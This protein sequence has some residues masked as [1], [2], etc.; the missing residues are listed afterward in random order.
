MNNFNVGLM[1][2]ATMVMVVYMSL[3]VTS[4]QSGFGEYVSYRTIVRDASGIFPKTPIKVAGINAGRIKKIELQQNNALITFEVLKRVKIS[5]DSKLRIKTVGF[6]GDKYLEIFIGKSPERLDP[7]SLIVS[8]EG[9]GVEGLVQNAG[10]VLADVKIIVNSLK[11]SLAPE[12]RPSPLKNILT[13]MEVL[14]DNTKK[15]TKTLKDMLG[16]N[17][18]RFNT[19]IKN[20]ESF[21]KNLA[22]HVDANEPDSAMKDV[23]G[24]LSKADKMMADLQTIVANLKSGKGTI[25]KL[26][27]EEDIADEVKETLSGIRK[28]VGKVDSLRTELSVYTGANSVYGAETS[29]GLKIF[30]SPERFY[31]LG[32]STSEFGIESEIHKTTVLN[33]QTS[34]EVTKTRRKDE[35]RFDVQLGRKIHNWSFRGGLIE[36]TGGIGIDYQLSRA[37]TLLTAELFDYRDDIGVNLRLSSQIHLW[38]V[39]Y[40]KLTFEDVILEDR[41]A[42][43]SAGL[44]FNDEDLKGLL[45]FFL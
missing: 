12:G 17:E 5:S 35:I 13:D 30:P 16:D 4:N 42:T 10:D 28:L 3:K 27:V 8:E 44:K 41:S 1:A 23:K 40:G 31:V 18:E 32:L 33:G 38:N 43:L 34:S 39:F 26:L 11:D 15:A 6:L 14:V 25:G 22:L 21:S 7:Q 45:G 29:A 20:L 19:M 36:S 9:G 2:I 24:I 37:G